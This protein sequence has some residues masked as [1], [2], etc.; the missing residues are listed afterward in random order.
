MT[1]DEAGGSVAGH[2]AAVA[3]MVLMLILL[4]FYL[5][6]GLLAPYWAVALLVMVWLGLF[7]LGVV[8]FRRHPFLVLLL[9]VVAVGVWLLVMIAGESLFGWTP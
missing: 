6:S 9:P 8:W 4:P 2:V 7:L 1:R 3:G 5:A